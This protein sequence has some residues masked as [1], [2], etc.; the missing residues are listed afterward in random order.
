MKTVPLTCPHCGFRS[1][2]HECE[3]TRRIPSDVGQV[4][5]HSCA[6]CHRV[7]ETFQAD[8]VNLPPGRVSWTRSGVIVSPGDD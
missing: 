7:W 5:M 4:R 8:P 2:K 6:R 3:R 1:R